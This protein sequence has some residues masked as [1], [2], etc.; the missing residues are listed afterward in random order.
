MIPVTVG[1]KISAEDA[2]RQRTQRLLDENGIEGTEQARLNHLTHDI[3]AAAIAVHNELGP[4]LLESAY[5]ACLT[6]ELQLRGHRVL[7]QVALPVTYKGIRVDLGYRLDVVVDDAVI[8]ELKTVEGVLPIHR[9]QLTSYLRL[10]GRRVGLLINFHAV[11]LV[12]GV[13][14]LVNRF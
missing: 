9:A 1:E 4:G 2:E 11:R 5:E 6:R 12:D 13:T 14:R 10:S 3:I 8:V 7:T